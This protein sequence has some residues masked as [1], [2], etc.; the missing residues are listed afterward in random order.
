MET[1]TKTESVKQNKKHS[2]LDDNH[3]IEVA[4]TKSWSKIAPFWPLKNLIAVNPIAGFEDLAFEDALKQANTYFQQKDIPKEMQNVNRETIKWLQVFFDEGQ[5]TIQMPL[6]HQGLLKST[7]SLL[8]FDNRLKIKCSQKKNWL[9]KLLESEKLIVEALS[10]LDVPI[11][12]QEQFLTLMLTTLPGWAAYIQYRT[13]WAETQG[14]KNPYSVRQDEYLALRLV[15]T[16]LIWPEA[17]KLLLW[18]K[19]ALKKTDVRKVYRQVSSSESLYQEELLKKLEAC[20]I[21]EKHTI[22][23]AQLVFCIDVRSEPFRR[24]LEAQGNYETYGFAGFFGVPVSIENSIT[25][26]SYASCPVLL[27]PVHSIVEQPRCSHQSYIRGY[28]RL[29][30]IKKLYQSL[31]YTFTTPFS[32]VETIGIGSGLWMFL[33]SLAPKEA[34]A[35]KSLLKNTVASDYSLIPDIKSIP[36]EQQV[37]YGL[38]A[39]KMMGL[40]DNFSQLIVFCGH[41]SSTQNNAYATALDCG[42]CG[43]HHGAPNARILA[44]ILN[45]SDVR[46]ALKEQN[47]CIP[48]NTYFVAAEHNT[49]TDQVKIYDYNAPN[50]IKQRIESLKQ[51]LEVARKENSLWRSAELGIKIKPNQAKQHT[52]VRAQDW[53]QVRPE[54]GLARNA[55][56][57]V[58]PR[59]L[60]KNINLNGRSFLHS[61]EWEKDHEGISLATILTAPMVVAQWINAQYFFST[62]DN[63]A[64][65]SGSK[66]TKNITGKIGVMQGNASDLMHGLPLQSVYKTDLEPYHQ[67]MRLT[68]IVYAPRSLIDPIIKEQAI[69]QKLFGNGWVHLICYDPKA[70]QKFRLQRDLTW[71]AV[72]K[73]DISSPYT[74]CCV[75]L[76]TKHQKSIALSAPFEEILGAGMLEYIVDTDQLGTFSGEVER[77]GTILETVRKKCEWSIKNTKVE[78]ALAS[79][80]SF[81]PNP[82]I[83]FISSNQEILYFIDKKRKFHLYVTDVYTETNYQMGEVSSF[84]ELYEFAEKALFP[85]HALIVRPYPKKIKGPIF[86]GIENQKDLEAAFL[87]AQKLSSY[88]KIWIE[89]DMR[90]HFNPTRMKMIHS[91]GEKLAH[92]LNTLCPK[93]S[94]PGWG[95]VSIEKGLPCSWCGSPTDEIKGEIFGCTKCDYKEFVKPSHGRHMADRGQCFCCNP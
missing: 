15:L 66:V 41:G 26:E 62:L 58:G 5:S 9:E 80:G 72:D 81:G 65:G 24:A 68:V 52:Y 64:F 88:K 2:T 59:W 25:G 89:T 90:A 61:Y 37:S 86:K 4:I 85:S 32:L 10:Y 45:S 82:M 49:T 14:A 16:C 54:W 11:H 76:T 69:L 35:I 71:I 30:G 22:P 43:G 17:K 40:T 83:P 36:F 67:P 60:T 7:L 75:I 53:A 56:F 38:G 92:R 57:I 63:V 55:A 20:N 3:S 46:E 31:K 79:E 12:E 44:M 33:R 1:I 48:D 70:K 18:H 78:Y 28:S 29:K 13:K 39:L 87:E 42:A 6:R 21:L 91:L 77:E 50:D 74:G 84:E 19:E 95:K 51:D 73:K 27:K 34:T 47:I 94:T 23:E 8:R 93:C